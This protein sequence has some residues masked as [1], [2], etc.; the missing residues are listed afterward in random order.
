[1][2]LVWDVTWGHCSEA[3]GHSSRCVYAGAENVTQKSNTS[4]GLRGGTR[5]PEGWDLDLK[6]HGTLGGC[7]A[8]L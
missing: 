6:V 3:L 4:C 1:M 8:Q 7:P 5:S 2:A